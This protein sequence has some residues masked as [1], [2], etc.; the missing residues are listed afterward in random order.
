MG[1]VLFA[2]GE[3][4]R[5]VAEGLTDGFP[6]AALA[7]LAVGFTGAVLRGVGDC[8]PLG[9][10]AAVGA[11][12]HAKH[13]ASKHMAAPFRADDLSKPGKSYTP[14]VKRWRNVS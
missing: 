4:A 7:P 11:A 12:G 2:E 14:T 6:V 13:R 8:A 3:G 10:G 1:E 5:P 9:D